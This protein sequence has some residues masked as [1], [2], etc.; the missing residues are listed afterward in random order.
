MSFVSAFTAGDVSADL[1]G[2]GVLDLGDLEAFLVEFLAG[3]P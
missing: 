2:N 1:D 3:C